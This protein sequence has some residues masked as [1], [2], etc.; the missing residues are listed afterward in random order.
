[1]VMVWLQLFQGLLQGRQNF[2]WFGWAT[3]LNGAGR[4]VIGGVIVIALAGQAAGLMLGVFA[5][6]LAAIVA[7]ALQNLDLLR[8]SGAP[9]DAWGWLKRVLPLTF[10]FGVS[11]FIFSAD[12][13]VAQ[14]YLGAN[15]NAADY[16]FGATLCRAI[17]LF[18]VP[19]AAVMFPKLVHSAARAQKTDLMGLTLLGTL[20]LSLMAVLGLTLVGP[21]LM[22]IFS[23]GH[24]EVIV[25]LLP[26]FAGGMTLLGLGNVLLYNMMAHSRFKIVPLLLAVA[27]G[28]WWTLQHYHESFRM[29]VQVFCIFALAYLG[30]CSLFTWGVDRRRGQ[31][32]SVQAP[33][34]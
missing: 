6:L 23:K 34:N 25:P 8:M 4:V 7:A 13:V 31:G 12:A 16:I 17:V 30:L 2:L 24:Y 22:K 18:T 32:A 1:L 11:T 29:I 26:L 3:I 21:Y 33:A 14:N 10:G 27:A 15:G 9:F 28:Y 5:G 19:L 20:G